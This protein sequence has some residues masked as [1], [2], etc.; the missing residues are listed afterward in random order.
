MS[1]QVGEFQ[2]AVAGHLENGIVEP[3]SQ[4]P[5]AGGLAAACGT[6]DIERFLR[7]KEPDDHVPAGFMEDIGRVNGRSVGRRLSVTF[8]QCTG[9]LAAEDVARVQIGG[10]KSA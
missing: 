10:L 9:S 5:D 2:P 1:H 7:I 3:G 8:D 6:E 4:L